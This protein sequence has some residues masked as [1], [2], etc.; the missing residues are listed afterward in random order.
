[1]VDRLVDAGCV[2]LNRLDAPA[3]FDHRRRAACPTT[4]GSGS[5]PGGDRS[6]KPCS[7]TPRTKPRGSASGGA[8]A[9]RSWSPVRRRSTVSPHVAGVRTSDG[10]VLHADLVVDAMGRRSPLVEWLT[11]LGA[12]APQVESEDHGFVYYTRY[13]AGPELPAMIGPPVVPMG[14]FSLLTLPGDNGTWSLTI[15]AAAADTVSAMSGI[16]ATST[17]C[18]RRAPS[19]CTGWMGSRIT[20]VLAMASILDKYRRFVVDDQPIA[21]G[22]AA[23]GDAWACTNPSAGRGISVGL[24]HA[25]CLR[26]ATR[27]GLDDPRD[28]RARVRRADRDQGGAVLLEPD[29]RR[30]AHASRRWTRFGKVGEPPPPDPTIDGIPEG[31]DVRRRRVPRHA[32]DAD[33]PRTSPRHPRSTRICSRRST[34]T[35]DA[36]DAMQIPGPSRSDLVELLT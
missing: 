3:S 28:V 15:W 5:S 21:T 27:A 20:D 9:S 31:R 4:T 13:F 12:R 23:V 32:R 11:A 26:D 1:M 24:F 2:W 22:V 29:R 14:T 35:A 19:T 7:R 36:P 18:C 25:Q 34:R 10:D 33:V 17:A 30:P 6:S 16:P 8:S